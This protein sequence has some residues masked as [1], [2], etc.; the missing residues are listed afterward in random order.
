MRLVRVI[1]LDALSIAEWT[2]QGSEIVPQRC[3]TVGHLV[4]ERDGHVIVAATI[5]GDEYNAA[6]Q[7][8]RSMIKR[9]F[10]LGEAA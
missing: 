6:Q 1:W 10:H 5:S 4:E 3:E 7:I 9:I 2:K 8:P